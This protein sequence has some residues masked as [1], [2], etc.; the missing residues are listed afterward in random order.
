[1]FGDLSR[2]QR[3][4]GV[5]VNSTEVDVICSNCRHKYRFKKDVEKGR[6]WDWWKWR[7]FLKGNQV[8]KGNLVYY[9]TLEVKFY[10]T[11]CQDILPPKSDY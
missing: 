11:H 9:S 7:V 1:M 2:H 4:Q 3:A 8:S 5:N 6:I 10:C